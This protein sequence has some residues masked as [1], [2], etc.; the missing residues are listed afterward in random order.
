MSSFLVTYKENKYEIQKFLKSHPAGEDILLPYKDKDITEAFDEIGHSKSALKI[1][2]KYLVEQP[3]LGNPLLEKVEQKE[4]KEE[5]QV[6]Y[7][8]NKMFRAFAM[9]SFVCL[10]FYSKNMQLFAE[11]CSN[12]FTTFRK[13]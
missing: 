10:I 2:N 7:N 1:L 6:K 8:I 11:Q 3:L 4:E 12:N 5:K 9:I 13:S